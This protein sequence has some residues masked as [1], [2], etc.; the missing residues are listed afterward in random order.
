M[1]E[2]EVTE[3]DIKLGEPGEPNTCAVARAVKRA[4]GRR[5]VNVDGEFVRLIKDDYKYRLPESVQKFITNFDFNKNLV[6]PLKF[7]L[8]RYK[9]KEK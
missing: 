5:M 1:I 7:K 3:R 8:P 6:R 2:V 9:R 4:T